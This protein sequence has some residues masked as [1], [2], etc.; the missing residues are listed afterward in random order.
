MIEVEQRPRA[1]RLALFGLGWVFFALGIIGAVLP[2]M[3]T[4]PFMLVALWCFAR[5]SRRFH[6]WL[7]RHKLF[8]PPLQSW[9]RH[10]IIPLGA[11]II[12]IASMIA[13][14]AY[15]IGFTDTAW[16]LLATMAASCTVGAVF[17]LTRPHR[18]PAAD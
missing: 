4:T 1:V 5:S 9:E 16:Y 14:M 2:V 12:A 7:L 15:V 8:G 3:P 6:R 11:K 17:I 13:S 18:R 10:G